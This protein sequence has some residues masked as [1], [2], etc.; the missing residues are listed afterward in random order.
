VKKSAVESYRLLIEAYDEATLSEQCA[1][2][3]FDA[4]GGDFDVEDKEYA[5]RPKLV[6]DAELEASLDEDPC[7]TQ[8]EL[9]ES[10]RVAQSTILMHLK[11][12]G[13]IQK[14][15]NWIP[16]ELKSRNLE[17]RVFTCEQLLQR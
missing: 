15:G 8:K 2:T 4:C 3:D 9:A 17:R 14:Q 1:V 13:M 7:Q 6:E 12:L 16:Y 5:G 10:L 11:A